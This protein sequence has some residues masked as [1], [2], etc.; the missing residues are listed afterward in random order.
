MQKIQKKGL[1]RLVKRVS[2]RRSSCKIRDGMCRGAR[3][4][5]KKGWLEMLIRK[6]S[7]S[8]LDCETRGRRVQKRQKKCQERLV[9][10]ARARRRPSRKIK[11]G[12]AQRSHKKG[13]EKLGWSGSR[14]EEVDL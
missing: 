11:Y 7:R 5:I 10:R 4:R 13:P 3:K 6:R 12:Y 14:A 9:K 2:A 1:K 8:V